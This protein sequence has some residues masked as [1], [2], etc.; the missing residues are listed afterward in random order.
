MATVCAPNDQRVQSERR[1]EHAKRVAR[2]L[3]A[4]LT[5]AHTV[6]LLQK[7]SGNKT[8][9]TPCTISTKFRTTFPPGT[10]IGGTALV[11]QGS[12]NGCSVPPHWTSGQ[13]GICASDDGEVS[14]LIATRFKPFGLEDDPDYICFN[15]AKGIEFFG[16]NVQQK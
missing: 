15:P 12:K 14:L 16:E 4:G 9:Y 7:Q 10:G 2:G 8:L 3:R 13:G 5:G 1:A 6:Q 11:G